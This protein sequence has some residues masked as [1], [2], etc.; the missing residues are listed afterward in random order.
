M[1]SN[2][3]I[4]ILEANLKITEHFQ[5]PEGYFE[6]FSEM[7][8]NK[9]SNQPFQPMKLM[10]HRESPFMRVAAVVSTVFIL[11]LSGYTLLNNN[12]AE[13]AQMEQVATHHI[14]NEG[15]G[16]EAYSIDEAAEYAMIDLQDIHELISE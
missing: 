6:S 2:K 12:S 14:S 15:H 8:T 10:I 13:N 11:A 16:D 1:N 4:D 3:E 7:M 9:L 5:V